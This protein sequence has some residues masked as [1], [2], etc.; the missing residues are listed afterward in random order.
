MENIVTQNTDTSISK[1]RKTQKNNYV[2]K[3][4]AVL[5]KVASGE[6][7]HRRVWSVSEDIVYL[8]SD[9]LYEDLLIGASRLWPIGF[10]LEDV[11]SVG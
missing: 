4:D 10:P 11:Q 2:K 5:A 3:G 1:H 6:W 7:V 8:C 9:R